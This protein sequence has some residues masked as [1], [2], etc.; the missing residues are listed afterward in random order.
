MMNAPEPRP[1]RRVTRIFLDRSQIQ[2]AR[3]GPLLGVIAELVSAKE[4][5]VRFR[6]RGDIVT[7]L[8]A[9]NSVSASGRSI[10]EGSTIRRVTRLGCA[11]RSTVTGMRTR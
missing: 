8:K 7:R 6:A 9:R 10:R 11:S 5:I 2:I 1:C 4:K 3:D